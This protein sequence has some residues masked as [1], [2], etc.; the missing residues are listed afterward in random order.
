MSV[1][2]T[3]WLVA[4]AHEVPQEL[5]DFGIL[6]HSGWKTPAALAYNAAS[7]LT[8]LLGGLIAN[9][10]SDSLDVAFLLPFAAG[11]FVYIAAADLVPQITS[12]VVCATP[13]EHK[14][15]LRER[16]SRRSPSPLVSPR[17]S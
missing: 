9:A 12:P 6:V 1:G 7:S 5:G 10:L 15:V 14:L 8:F 17:G 2:I 4:A 16:S 3:T 11:N 13:A